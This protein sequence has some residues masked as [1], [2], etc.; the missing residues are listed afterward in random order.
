MRHNATKQTSAYA[1]I[2]VSV[3]IAVILVVALTALL[4]TLVAS[5]KMGPGKVG[6]AVIVIQISAAFVS[7]YIAGK[8]NNKRVTGIA[9]AALL[10]LLAITGLLIS[11]ERFVMQWRGVVDIIL[12]AAGAVT[13][14]LTRNKRKHSI[15]KKVRSR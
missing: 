11:G 2:M 8:A 5:E 4:T 6:Y 1:T 7:C 9:I 3:V 10:T 15:V 13:L 12:G 14:Q